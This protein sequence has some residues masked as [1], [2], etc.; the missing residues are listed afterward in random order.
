MPYKF[1]YI[2][3]SNCYIYATWG[4]SSVG[5]ALE[6][7]SR[8]QRFDPAY[9][10]FYFFNY[11]EIFVVGMTKIREKSQ[12]I[13]GAFLV[14]FLASLSLGGLVGGA[15]IIDLTI[16]KIYFMLGKDHPQHLT[17]YAGYAGDK[18]IE[19]QEFERERSIQINF[20]RN[21]RG[22]DLDGQ[23]ILGAENS[24]WNRLVDET[25]QK[26]LIEKLGLKIS[27]DELFQYIFMQFLKIIFDN[28]IAEKL[29]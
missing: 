19:R 25:I 8:G 27:N 28:V 11:L 1:S 17:R 14:I 13:L 9:L 7:H 10:H 16:G 12:Y 23:A 6:W 29:K 26:P 20:Q 4:C 22:T 2:V 3:A 24:A 18:W 15:N 21:N 5:R